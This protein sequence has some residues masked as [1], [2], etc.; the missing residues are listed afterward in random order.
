MFFLKKK[1][2]IVN[3]CA[4]FAIKS[5]EH[6]KQTKNGHCVPTDIRNDFI[7]INDDLSP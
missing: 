7:N 5:Q 1:K 2:K 3:N 4:N 6:D